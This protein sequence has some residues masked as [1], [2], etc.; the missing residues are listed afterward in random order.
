MSQTV[1]RIGYGAGV[2]L[3]RQSANDEELEQYRKEHDI[4]K[5]FIESKPVEDYYSV[6]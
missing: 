5:D 6:P 1:H 2:R 4:I 3:A